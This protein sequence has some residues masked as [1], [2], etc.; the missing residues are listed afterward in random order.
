MANLLASASLVVLLSDYEA[1]PVAVM[2]AASL[3]VPVLATDTSGFKELADQRLVR[4]IPRSAAAEDI[5]A[6]M[7][8]L[9]ENPPP[10]IGFKLPDWQDCADRLLSVY[11]AIAR[12]P[13]GDAD[14]A[15]PSTAPLG[16]E[17]SR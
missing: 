16:R 17:F 8:A 11:R 2:E 1:H 14:R 6:E 4:A 10:P 15:A 9:I 7:A 5:A 12:S 3:N 13:S